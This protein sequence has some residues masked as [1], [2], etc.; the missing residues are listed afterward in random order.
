MGDV[1]IFLF[2]KVLRWE[3]FTD[4]AVA[5]FFVYCLLKAGRRE[6]H[7]RGETIPAG[8]FAGTIKGMA[9]ETGLSEKQ[10]RRAIRCLCETGE[11][12]ADNRANR[13]HLIKVLH[14]ADYQHLPN[15]RRA[16]R[17]NDQGKDQGNDRGMEHIYMKE[18]KRR[19]EEDISAFPF[20]EISP[21]YDP[22]QP[23]E[24]TEEETAAFYERH[25]KGQHETV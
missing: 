23:Q 21:I 11:L 20:S 9:A 22:N 13:G 8:A 4:P 3:W 15:T 24:P 7:Y 6:T 16:D 19:R 10:I 25:K 18:K 1:F 5:H 12:K 2:A 14:Y 17:G